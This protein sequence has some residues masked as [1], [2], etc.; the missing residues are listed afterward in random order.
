MRGSLNVQSSAGQ[1]DGQSRGS[2][3]YLQ[4]NQGLARAD[5]N[6]GMA[7]TYN[8][9]VPEDE[10]QVETQ[11]ELVQT[12]ARSTLRDSER[13]DGEVVGEDINARE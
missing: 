9:R 10:V 12:M 3:N 6:G 7:D 11:A 13:D 2:S 1:I 5:L 4:S 8:Q